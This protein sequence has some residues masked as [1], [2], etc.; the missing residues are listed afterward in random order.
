MSMSNI[1]KNELINIDPLLFHKE[2]TCVLIGKIKKSP[3]RFIEIY[4]IEYLFNS[5]RATYRLVFFDNNSI[6]CY[7]VEDRPILINNV[8]LFP[9]GKELGN[10]IIIND[11][12]PDKIYLNGEVIN[13]LVIK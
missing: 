9:Y 1:R 5:T 10:E 4:F 11:E 2:D 12:I 6:F 13:K 8:L 3:N 7:R